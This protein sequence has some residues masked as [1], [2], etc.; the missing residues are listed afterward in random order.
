MRVESSRPAQGGTGGWVHRLA[1]GPRVYVAPPTRNGATSSSPPVPLERRNRVYR[2]LLGGASLGGRDLHELQRRGFTREEIKARRYG[3]LQLR[4][5]AGLAG[6]ILNGGNDLRGIPGFY[7]ATNDNGDE[8][9]TLAGSPGL[10]I[11]CLDVHG[12]IRGLRIRPHEQGN[13][14]A[15]Y[16]WF[17][18]AKK[19]GGSASGVHCH[20]ARPLHGAAP[21]D[22]TVW[23]VEGE[24]KADLSVPRLGAVVVSIP[25]VSTWAAALPDLLELLPR[26]GRVVV[27]LDA[28]WCDKPEVHSALWN[29]CQSCSALGFS[30]E[31]ALWDLKDG[32][33]LDDLLTA[34][35]KPTR[36]PPTAIPAPRW[37]IKL[38]SRVMTEVPAQATQV[39][40]RTLRTAR[41][42]LA[43]HLAWACRYS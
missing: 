42:A 7:V 27:A 31:V 18:S 35:S 12:Q 41:K 25:G 34:G 9:W 16:I 26:G 21:P 30:V 33:G 36:A 40:A 24:L 10:L 38:S 23:I 1:E 22:D 20:V 6:D 5:R 4:G 11:P 28:D 8:Y 32:K 14:H 43:A 17:S 2:Q 37:P 15:K 39:T 29:L 3:S 13:G 19:H